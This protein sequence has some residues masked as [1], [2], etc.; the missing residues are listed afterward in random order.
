MTVSEVGAVLEELAPL[1]HAENFDNVGLLIGRPSM[2]V[3]GILVTLDTLEHVVDEAIAKNCNLVVSFHPIIFQ[4]LKKLTASTYVERVAMKAI[5]N[6]IAIFS[7]HT[8]LDNSPLGVNYK[9]CEVLGL[10]KRKILIPKKDSLKKLVTYVPR[11]HADALREKLFETGAGSLGNYSNCSFVV[12]GEGSFRAGN[13][14]NPT[15]GKVGETHFEPETQINITFPADLEAT[16]L[17]A[18]FT[19]HP[20]EEVDYEIT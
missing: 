15:I 20:Y 9:I 5:A 11:K 13:Q 16:V 17:S 14:A 3:K 18:L 10:Q 7:P 6:N 19:H 1:S 4:G 12:A 2:E 8:A